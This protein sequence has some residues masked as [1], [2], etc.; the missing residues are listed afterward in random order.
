MEL[1]DTGHWTFPYIF[2]ASEWFGFIYR[3][4]EISTGREYIGKKQFHSSIRKVVK[5]ESKWKTYT[6]SSDHL[7]AA[8]IL[9]GVENYVFAI[10]SL[11]KTKGSLSYAEVRAQVF[12]D[13]LRTKLIDGITPKYYNKQIGSCRFIPPTETA[14]E[15]EMKVSS[16]TNNRIPN[17]IIMETRDHL[18]SITSNKIIMDVVEV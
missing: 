16:Y 3:I 5:K 13:V 6:S 4:T 7:N 15:A 10:E 14:E 11:H 1:Y 9:N 12:E 18:I 17:N 2:D 8:I